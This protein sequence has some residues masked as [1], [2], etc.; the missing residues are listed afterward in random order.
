MPKRSR[1]SPT[2]YIG[3]FHFDENSP[4]GPRAGSFQL[5]VEA[6]SA[7]DAAERCHARLCELRETTPLFDRSIKIYFEGVVKLAGSFK[8]GV[9]INWDSRDAPPDLS[10]RL[11]C[12]LPPEQGEHAGTIDYQVDHGEGPIEP[13]LEFER[14]QQRTRSPAPN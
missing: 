8:H 12:L 4:R 2:L 14:E 9:L 7:D 6:T 5:V 11:S 13:F 3:C 10:M 1:S